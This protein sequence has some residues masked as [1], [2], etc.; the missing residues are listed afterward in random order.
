MSAVVEVGEK[1]SPF[2]RIKGRIPDFFTV[3][4]LLL[5]IVTAFS[6]RIYLLRFYDVISADG[7]GYVAAARNL[8]T[9]DM[10]SLSSN[11]FYVFMTWLVGQFT[12]DFELSGR[13][14]SVIFGSVLVV[15]LYLLGSELFSRR[16]AL[17]ACLV[18]SVWPSLLGWSCEVM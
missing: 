15:P 11:G 18:T 17:A 16:T 12:P 4:P 6:V 9:G 5:I 1:S 7:I 13:L 10:N 14:V 2:E 3:V 8:A